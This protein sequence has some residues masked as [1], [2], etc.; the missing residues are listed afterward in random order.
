MEQGIQ[1]HNFDFMGVRAALET[2]AMYALPCVE[3]SLLFP[4]LS[5]VFSEVCKI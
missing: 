3:L 5:P 2:R 4:I 1:T